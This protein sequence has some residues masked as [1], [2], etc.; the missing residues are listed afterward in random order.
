VNALLSVDAIV[1]VVELGPTARPPYRAIVRGYDMGRTKYN[2]GA[3]YLPGR[4]C[5]G[6]W[7]AFP[8]EVEAEKS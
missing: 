2:L 5:D 1:R 4:F 7:W 6:G 8:S 3:E